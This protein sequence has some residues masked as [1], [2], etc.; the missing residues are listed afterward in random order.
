MKVCVYLSVS[1]IFVSLFSLQA[2]TKQDTL[3]KKDSVISQRNKKNLTDSNSQINP[4]QIDTGNIINQIDTT[5]SDTTTNVDS[6]L[7]VPLEKKGLTNTQIFIYILLSVIG[8]A[9][10]FF[11]FV[12]TLFRTFHKTRSTRQSLLLSWNL[13][14]VVSIIWLFIIWGIVAEFWNESAFMIVII[15]LFIISLIMTIIAV[16]SK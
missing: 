12:Q 8:L 16:K 13:F 15:F 1:L 2:Q 6:L 9:L 14:F 7:F 3:K 4:I 11:I 10:F 5:I